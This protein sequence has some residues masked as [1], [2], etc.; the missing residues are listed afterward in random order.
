MQLLCVLCKITNIICKSWIYIDANYKYSVKVLKKIESVPKKDTLEWIWYPRKSEYI[1]VILHSEIY[2]N[3][4]NY[5]YLILSSPIFDFLDMQK[6]LKSK[7]FCSSK[8][9]HLQM[10]KD[11]YFINICK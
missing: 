1:E 2:S 9:K 4:A 3:F 7:E 6:T 10:R 8:Y 5:H 11:L